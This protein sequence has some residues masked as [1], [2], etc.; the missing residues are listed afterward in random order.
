[1]V[2]AAAGC[3]PGAAGTG[4]GETTA[5]ARTAPG[6]TLLPSGAGTGWNCCGA[7]GVGGC[8]S[9]LAGSSTLGLSRLLSASAGVITGSVR[10]SDRWPSELTITSSCA[11]LS[12]DAIEIEVINRSL[13]TNCW[14]VSA[15]S[16]PLTPRTGG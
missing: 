6:A 13:D 5:S 7:A 16:C 2:S 8:D 12:Q 3:V 15:M 10:H 14:F 9:I 1:M 11:E 4:D